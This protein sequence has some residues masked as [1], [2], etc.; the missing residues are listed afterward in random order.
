MMMD[1]IFM[2]TGKPTYGGQKS[3]IRAFE[4]RSDADDAK[5]LIDLCEPRLEISIE[6][7]NFVRSEWDDEEA[8]AAILALTKDPPDERS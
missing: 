4:S 1:K 8:E 6:E 5:A 3:M 7:V 2:M